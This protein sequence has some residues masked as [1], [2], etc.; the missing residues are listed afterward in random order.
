MKLTYIMIVAVLFLTA[1]TFVTADDSRNVLDNPFLKARHE[2]KNPQ[3]SRSR[4]R[5]RPRGTLCGFPKPGP[6]CCNG[7]CIVFCV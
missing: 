4:G 1:W 2:M 5:C 7:W 3:A 6:Y